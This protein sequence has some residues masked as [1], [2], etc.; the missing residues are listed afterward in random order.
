M[1]INFE[2]NRPAQ[3]LAC[4]LVLAFVLTAD[5]LLLRY[6]RSSSA[7]SIEPTPLP[8]ASR[9]ED[10]T[11][12]ADNPQPST[13]MVATRTNKAVSR[14][15]TGLPGASTRYQAQWGASPERQTKVDHSWIQE[16]V[17]SVARSKPTLHSASFIGL[18]GTVLAHTE[19]QWLYTNMSHRKF[20]REALQGNNASEILHAAAT[21]RAFHVSAKPVK[22]DGQIIGVL[23]TTNEVS[24]TSAGM[25]LS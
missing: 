10:I 9:W 12:P 22:I 13:V 23:C 19:A 1:K 14:D 11:L 18:D 5:L 24:K 3:V 7:T 4:L 17:R 21:A 6:M 15:S 8:M 20:F 25:R 16:L 2:E